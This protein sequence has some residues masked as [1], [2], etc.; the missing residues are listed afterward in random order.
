[1]PLNYWRYLAARVRKMEKP[2]ARS[3][4]LC[5]GSARRKHGNEMRLRVFRTF[6]LTHDDHLVHNVFD[7]V[8]RRRSDR[9]QFGM[10]DFLRR[11]PQ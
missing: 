8:A 3:S 5:A 2:V 4:K 1:M 10:S 6:F 7:S 11:N 9:L